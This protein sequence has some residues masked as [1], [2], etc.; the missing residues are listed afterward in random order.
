MMNGIIKLTFC[1]ST[2]KTHLH[3]FRTIAEANQ[4]INTYRTCGKGLYYNFKMEVV[5]YK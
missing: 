3:L 5:K 2:G 1:D 4:M